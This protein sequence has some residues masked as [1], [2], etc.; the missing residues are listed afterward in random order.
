MRIDIK[1]R[2]IQDPIYIEE[3]LGSTLKALM[4]GE[5]VN[6]KQ[7]QDVD[8]V[9]YPVGGRSSPSIHEGEEEI[10]YILRGSG[11]FYVKD[12]EINAN[13]GQAIAVPA[14]SKHWVKNT[15]ACPLHYLVCTARL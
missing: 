1:I 8:Y 10:F 4:R 11:T 3:E 13:A 9:I 5:E 12:R 15:G 7:I 14:N 2:D 6:A